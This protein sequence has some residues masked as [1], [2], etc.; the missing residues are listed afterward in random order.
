MYRSGASCCFQSKAPSSAESLNE[1]G[2]PRNQAP[3]KHNGFIYRGEP[4][5]TS[6]IYNAPKNLP[7]C[8]KPLNDPNVRY[9]KKKLCY[10]PKAMFSLD[11]FPVKL[12]NN[13][14]RSDGT[15]K[16]KGVIRTSQLE[17]PVW[18]AL[19][20]SCRSE[21]IGHDMNYVLCQ[22]TGPELQY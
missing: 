10:R 1:A 12:I 5:L 8:F 21:F 7:S 20:S 3:S 18:N 2:L 16:I 14:S 11:T 6:R 9:P 13:V 15:I 4:W 17:Y 19:C 22:W